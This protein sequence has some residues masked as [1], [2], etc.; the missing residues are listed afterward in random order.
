M[1]SSRTTG[2]TGELVAALNRL[3]GDGNLIPE[4]KRF[5]PRT[6]AAAAALLVALVGGTW[7]LARSDGA[8][9]PHEP[10][11]VLIA[12]FTNSAKDPV[13]TGL[14]EQA[15]A[16]GIESASFVEAFSRRDALRLARAI[17]PDAA[18]DEATARLISIREGV[19][20]ILAGDVSTECSGYQLR[21]DPS[22]R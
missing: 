19:D 12:D 15:L 22:Q 4:P 5:T 20:V 16:I 7:W 3:D 21:S 1:S 14:V 8:D 11:S 17:R 13:F 18:L 9:G 10:V 2:T 6:A